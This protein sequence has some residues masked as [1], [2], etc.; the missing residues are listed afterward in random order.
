MT[1]KDLNVSRRKFLVGGSALA[2]AG[3]VGCANVGSLGD[4][5][6]FERT[7]I[8]GGFIYSADDAGTV[9]PNGWVLTRGKEIEAIGPASTPAP[10]AD[11]MIDA[12]GKMVLPGFVNPHWHES[13]VEGP[14]RMAPDD[15]DLAQMPFSHGGDIEA[16]S[17]YFGVIADVGEK[18]TPQEA[19][20]IARW[21]MWTQLRSGT[22]A[23]GDIGSL[24]A[25]DAMAN[26]AID[27]GMRIRVSRWGSDIMIPN[28]ATEYKRIAPW[29][30]QAA[31]WDR[32]MRTWNNHSSGLVGG[33]PSILAAFGS[34]DEQLMALKRIADSYGAPYAAHMAPLRNEA[35]ALKPIFGHSAIG[36]FQKHGLLT[37]RL[38]SVHTCHATIDEYAA[39]VRAGVNIVYSPAN[40]ALLGEHTITDTHMAHQFLRDGV[41]VSCST[42]GNISYTGGMPEAM[43]ALF[44]MINE[45]SGDNTAM[46][47]NA[48]LAT[49]T[50]NG[51]KALAWGDKIGSLEPGKEA[52][53]VI[54]DI[55]DW[56][57]RLITHPLSTFLISGGSQDVD[58]VMVAGKF[59]VR[60]GKAVNLNEADMFKAY[61]TAVESARTRIFGA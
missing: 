29:E 22:T 11:R 35:L 59:V 57:Y 7:L 38:L 40:Y 41:N 53:L 46:S 8:H 12:R 3:L 19:I 30:K 32:L 10:R 54:V 16:L 6:N 31:D 33:M 14:E 36:R 21:S 39:I 27:L 42:D 51:A 1:Y 25:T 49:G 44:L 58:S 20:A 2:S 4:D 34:S 18:L 50:I 43:R 28:G 13:F 17:S 60:D 9:H 26:A 56:R 47:P 5:A 48:A 23:L 24:N 15:S 37:G 55:D 52:D 45:S 61:E